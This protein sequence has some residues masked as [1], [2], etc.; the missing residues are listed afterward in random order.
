MS[1]RFSIAAALLGLA[2]VALT[3]C[4]TV[5]VPAAPTMAWSVRRSELQ[6]LERF[7]LTG[8]VAVAVAQQGFNAN[9]RWAQRGTRTRMVLSGPLGADAAQVTADGTSLSV[10][11]PHGRH[12]GDAAAQEILE[13]Q[14]GFEPPL[15]SLRYWVLGVPDPGAP[16]TVTLDAE[17][18]LLRLG[19]DGWSVD[20]QSYMSVGA[21]WLPRLLTVRRAGVRL[22][23][24]VDE[25]LLQ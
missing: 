1:L 18:R 2:A 7:H 16:A 3:A 10:I 5:Q 6:S 22:R 19:Q 11:T 25:W 15:A 23:M 21:A 8:R 13:R 17:H 12:L 9:I 4:Q 20:Y 24:V 14:L